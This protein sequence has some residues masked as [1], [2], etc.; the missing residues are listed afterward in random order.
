MKTK[1][2]ELVASSRTIQT[3]STRKSFHAKYFWQNKTKEILSSKEM[4]DKLLSYLDYLKTCDPFFEYNISKENDRIM[5]KLYSET[6]HKFEWLTLNPHTT[7][8]GKTVLFAKNFAKN[9]HIDLKTIIAGH[10]IMDDVKRIFA[11]TKLFADNIIPVL[12]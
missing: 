4:K 10:M 9:I 12:R 5:V 8:E 7:K 2:Y 11:H 3:H 1:N 6:T